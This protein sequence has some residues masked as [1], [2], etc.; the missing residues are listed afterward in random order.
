M[1]L[2]PKSYLAQATIYIWRILYRHFKSV[3]FILTTWTF[4]ESLS[5]CWIGRWFSSMKVFMR[6]QISRGASVTFSVT[7][8]WREIWKHGVVF[9]VRVLPEEESVIWKYNYNI[10][11]KSVILALIPKCFLAKSLLRFCLQPKAKDVGITWVVVLVGFF[12][13]SM[14]YQLPPPCYP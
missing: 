14:H 6:A 13:C 1:N 7:Q 8:L 5:S 4:W 3:V 2:L 11:A 10:Y 12:I 9:F